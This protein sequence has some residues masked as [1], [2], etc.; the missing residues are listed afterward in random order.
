MGQLYGWMRQLP[1]VGFNSGSYD[2]NVIKQFLVPYF[3]SMSKTEEQEER[4]QEEE[5]SMSKTEEQE[6]RKQEEEENEGVGS[7]FVIKRNNTFMCLS[8]DQLK[9]L[10]MTNYIAPGFSYDKYLKAYGCEVTKGHFPYEYMDRL[11]KLDDTVL[12]PKEAF[13]SRLKNEGIS[14][15]DYASCQEAWRDNDMTTLRDFLVW[16]NNRDVVPFLQAI[17][18]QFDLY[19]QRGIE[20]FKQGISVPGLTLLYLFNDLPEKTYFTIFNEK[21]KDLHDLVKD[22]I[23]GGPSIIFHRYHEKGITTLRRNEYA[24]AARSCRS[25]VGYD[26][27]AL[28][29]W[30]LMQDMPMGWY[31]RRRVE[32]DFRPESAQLYGQM[33]A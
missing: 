10:D 11:E 6:E 28:Y 27:N 29:L 25:I 31:T 15:E 5:E 2:L 9:F 12:P 24:E 21:K 18:R 19:Q 32:K 22:N 26:A 3:L 30:S 20:M 16:Y 1:V 23:C 7:F 8:T 4:K 13:F 14:D 17:D 33:A